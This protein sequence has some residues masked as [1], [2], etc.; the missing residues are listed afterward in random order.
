MKQAS[1]SE[2]L[3]KSVIKSQFTQEAEYLSKACLLALQ[4]LGLG[5]GLH[6]LF[7]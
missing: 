4:N 1:F 6:S 7:I 2:H 5:G 3:S